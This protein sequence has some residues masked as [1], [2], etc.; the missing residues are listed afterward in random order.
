MITHTYIQFGDAYFHQILGIPMG[1]G[2]APFMANLFLACPEFHFMRNLHAD[3]SPTGRHLFD[4]FIYTKRFIDDLLVIDN[5]HILSLMYNTQTYLGHRGL[6]PSC[7]KLTRQAHPH[8]L[9]VPFLD[10]LLV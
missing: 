10:I 4:A 8:P 5:P 9:H 7:L 6:Y 3:T 1:I 2:P